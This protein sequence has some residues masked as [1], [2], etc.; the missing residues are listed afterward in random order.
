MCIT[1]LIW[2][3][4]GGVV[5]ASSAFSPALV[6]SVGEPIAITARQVVDAASFHKPM[7]LGGV[8]AAETDQIFLDRKRY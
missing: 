8:L 2:A 4:I 5:Y 7:L 6:S 3:K 1:A